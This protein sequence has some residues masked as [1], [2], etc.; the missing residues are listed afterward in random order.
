M[1]HPLPA[2]RLWIVIEALKPE[3]LF[4]IL[5]CSFGLAVLFANGPFQAPDENDHYARVFQL[6]EGTLIGEKRGNTA[7]GELPRAVASVTDT[8]GIPFHYEKKM[9]RALF[10]RLSHPVFVDWSHAPRAYHYFP[11]TVVYPPAGYLPQTLALFLGRSLRIGP[12]GL[13]YLAR[14]GGFA[15]SVALGF[16]ALRVLPIYRWTTL[17]L[18]LCPMSLYLFGSIASDGVMIAGAA[19]LVACL[20]R[21][22]VQPHRPID[23]WEQTII[24]GLAGILALA[25]PVYLP[26]AGVALFVVLPKLGSLRSKVLFCAAIVVFCLLPAV[27]WFQVASAL[28]APADGDVPV[29]P[30]AQAHYILGAPLAF[31][32]LVAHTIRVQYIVNFQWMVGTLGWGDTPMPRWFYSAFG[33]GILGC[34]VLESEGAKQIRSRLRTV[35]VIAVLAS[36][37]LIYVAQYASWNPPGSRNPIV[38]IEGRY[39]L[40]LLYLVVLSFP[41]ISIKSPELFIVALASILS[42]LCAAICLWAVIFR[43]YITSAPNVR[44]ARLT[45]LSTQALVGTRENILISGFVVRGHGLETLL[46][47]ADGPSLTKL[48][49]S[50]VLARPSL[51]VLDSNGTL[52]ASNTEWGTNPNPAQISIASAAV[53]AVDLPSKSAD[54]ALILSVPEGSYTVEIRGASSTTGVAKEEIYELSSSGTRLSNISSRSYVGK[55]AN[56]MTV[57]FVVG[58]TGIEALLGRAVGPSLTQFGVIGALSQPTLEISPFHSGALI[59]NAWGS[60]PAKA[61][62][63]AAAS[64]IGAFPLAVD[65]ADSAAVFSVHPGTYTMKVVGSGGATGV[66]LAE[67]YELP[68]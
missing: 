15:A 59:S 46:I 9:S 22:E 54:S 43:Y 38:G 66:A 2:S 1:K 62:I 61:D 19:L 18:L 33:Y 29:N 17:V 53:G 51:D 64:L 23:L 31:L 45:N 24:L 60:S 48:G 8:E 7:G 35:L 25:K 20:A 13:M 5:A 34:L 37:L 30:L 65:S 36:V 26:F 12:L 50:G 16:A 21:L 42:V 41:R 58:G 4:L 56:S 10:E 11:H 27:I 14:L 39:F 47:R 52:L 32:A 67:I 40:P 57:G 49:L 3:T 44:L 68:R 28:Y 63:S 55:G 6:S